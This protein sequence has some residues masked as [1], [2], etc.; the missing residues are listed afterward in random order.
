MGS[1]KRTALI[2]VLALV[3]PAAAMAADLY[4]PPPINYPPPPVEIGSNWYLRG[5]IGY[6]IYRAPNAFFD[7]PGY[8]NFIDETMSP[9]FGVGIGA[10]YKFGPHFRA[11]ITADYEFPSS[12]RGRL[13]CPDP[14]TGA[15][16]EEYSIETASISAWT[17][18]VN[19]YWDIAR[20]GRMTP[21]LGGGVGVSYLTTT[22]V[23]FTN[24]DGTTGTWGGASRFNLAWA[25]MAGA[26]FD[27]TDHWA[28]D[29][30]YRFI[31]LG[32]AQ[33][34]VVQAVSSTQPIQYRNISGHEFR[35]GLRYSIW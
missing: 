25:L 29:A 9:V 34:A 5:D 35:V 8:G 30:N 18:M 11:D 10:G 28:I 31:N 17:G 15:P 12:F 3:M 33:S 23:A 13:I 21:Y 26:S 1:L 2:G 16:G 7:E 27:L 14:C 24:P 20:W 4:T 19:A 6:K 22:N 32:T